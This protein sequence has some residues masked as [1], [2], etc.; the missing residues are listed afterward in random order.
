MS[1]HGREG[2]FARP[3][4]PHR[5]ARTIV[6][7]CPL[8]LAACGIDGTPEL[9]AI[10]LASSPFGALMVSEKGETLMPVVARD[11][12]GRATGVSA[13]LWMDGTGNSAYVEM[14]L[15][16]GRP[17]RTV[18]GDFIVLFSN[19]RENGTVVDIARIYGP[20]NY[21]EVFRGVRVVQEPA[22]EA[23]RLTAAA[24]CLPDCPSTER[25][26]AELLK[27]TALGLSIGTC[28]VAVGISWGAALLPCTGV[29]VSSAK[30]LTG[31]EA[32]VNA[33]LDR[34]GRLLTAVDALQCLGGDPGGCVSLMLEGASN[35]VAKAAA[36]VEKYAALEQDANDRLMNPQAA[37]GLVSGSP[38]DC[39]DSYLCT[40]GAYLPC[41]PEGTKQCQPDC[42]WTQCPKPR[43]SGGTCSPV[44]DG[45]SACAQLVR[46]VQAQCAAKNGTIVSWDPDEATCVKGYACWSTNCPCVMSC[47]EEC[48]DDVACAQDCL[49]R[50]GTDLQTA[51]AKCASCPTPAVR[52][53][54]SYPR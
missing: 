7:L 5:A 1:I 43:P 27:V 30:M 16:T 3:R 41:Y 24:T 12:S 52:A 18:M 51:A 29:V 42:T 45:P 21:A 49:A 47:G 31:E 14:D 8:L 39:I 53:Q 36:T 20:T 35:E 4:G 28:G 23:G 2:G 50:S 19:W 40:P 6:L 15:V 48:Q 33:P 26:V 10:P 46:S 44:T 11:P 22:A 38:P 17:T 37:P 54:C 34:A 9:A 13:A 25:T 32:W